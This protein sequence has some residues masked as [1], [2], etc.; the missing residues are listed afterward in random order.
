VL[1]SRPGT[2]DPAKVIVTRDR[3]GSHLALLAARLAD[4]PEGY[5]CFR[6]GPGRSIGTPMP[7]RLRS[8]NQVYPE[9]GNPHTSECDSRLKVIKA[10]LSSGTAAKT[11]GLLAPARTD[12]S[13]VGHRQLRGSF[14]NIC[15]WGQ[16]N[17]SSEAV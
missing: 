2:A 12:T 6:R 14:R 1:L 16:Y 7:S 17:M 13:C 5:L 9:S 11:G 4:D 8:G 15:W 10:A 3:A